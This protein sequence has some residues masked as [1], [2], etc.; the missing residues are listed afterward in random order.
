MAER[1]MFAKTIIDSDAFLDMPL[2]SQ[3]LYFHLSMRADDEGFI[4]NPK[5]IQRM[6]GCSDDDLKI[7]LAKC[8]IIPFESGIVV[9]KHW[10]IN[11]YIQNDRFKPTLYT[12]ERARLTVKDNGAYTMNAGA[13]PD[14]SNVYT[15]CIQDVYET[16]TQVSIGKRSVDKPSTDKP[17][18]DKPSLIV[19]TEPSE[20]SAPEPIPESVP[21]VPAIGLNDGSEWRPTVADM[22]EWQK[23]YSGV[24]VVREL[25]RMRQW[26]ISNPT[27][28]KTKRGIRRFVVNWLDSAQNDVSR[29]SSNRQLN[30]QTQRYEAVE[31]WGKR[32]EC[33]NQG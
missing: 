3:A 4:N 31:R 33:T 2:S 19:C 14:V 5:K 18:I 16:D 21:D 6:I 32:Y 10:K 30:R 28:R 15:D 22:D 11:N 17:S 20:V 7:L 23:L 1:R 29:K 25:A 8:F 26:C 9:I 13:L 27:K 12:D 24:D